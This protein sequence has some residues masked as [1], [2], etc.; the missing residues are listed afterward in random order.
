MKNCFNCG[1]LLFEGAKFCHHCG[2]RVLTEHVVCNRCHAENSAD[3]RFCQNCGQNFSQKE[4]AKKTSQQ[5]ANQTQSNEA[6]FLKQAFFDALKKRIRDEHE[7]ALYPAYVEEIQLSGFQNSLEARIRILY[8]ELETLKKRNAAPFELETH[9]NL[10]LEE[11]IDF[12][13][14]RYC[15]HLNKYNLPE[16]FLK[17]QGKKLTEINLFR[18]CEDYLDFEH[19]QENF[20][21]D[22]IQMPLKKLQ[23]ASASFLKPEKSEKILFICDQSFTGTCKEGFAMTDEAIYWKAHLQKPQ[24]VSYKHLVEIRTEQE[25]LLINGLF[26]NVNPGLNFKLMKLLKKLRLL[27]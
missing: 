25:W 17:Y 14:F 5:T 21:T 16:V 8:D 18:M 3:A 9:K 20:Y 7:E 6:W 19:E 4:E 26:F 11:L 2:S 12:F 23:N 10:V 13:I 24:K 15:R 27:F 1:T 22:F